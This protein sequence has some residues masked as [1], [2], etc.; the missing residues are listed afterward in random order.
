MPVADTCFLVDLMRRRPAA[1]ELYTSYEEQDIALS[2]TAVTALELYK[3][4]YLSAR[5]EANLEKIRL[6]L[7]IFEVLPFNQQIFEV[8]G[9]FSA[10][11]KKNGVPIG[12][13]DEVIAS[14]A[15]CHDGVL[16]TRDEHF[17]SVRG[18]KVVRY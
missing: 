1:I 16:I 15:L 4:A 5:R 9:S 3:G 14:I 11:L 6:M 18:L 2:T 8:F 10:G 13:F 7:S 12:D 17:S